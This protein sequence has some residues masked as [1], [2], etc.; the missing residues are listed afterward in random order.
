MQQLH[1]GVEQDFQPARKAP[2]AFLV[3][4]LEELR[5]TLTAAGIST[6]D[7]NHH[8]GTRRFYASD[9]WGNRLEFVES[10]R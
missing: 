8:P 9:S 5:A 3:S 2:P 10:R 7:D 1:M 6:L 4:D